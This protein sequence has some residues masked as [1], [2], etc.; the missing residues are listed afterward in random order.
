[1]IEFISRIP[2]A[3]AETIPLSAE[4]GKHIAIAKR[5]GD[6]WFVGV[7]TNNEARQVEIDFSFLPP[8]DY[9]AEV[10]R[11]DETTGA[12]AKAITREIISVN[13]QSKIS[14][15]LAAGG[16]AAIYISNNITGTAEES[17]RQFSIFL[18]AEG[19]MMTIQSD[20]IIDMLYIVDL[21]G[22]LLFS[23]RP[24]FEGSWSQLDISALDA[25]KIY[26]VYGVF[27]EQKKVFSRK[28]VKP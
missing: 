16:G 15:A 19:T 12:N 17:S 28:F 22:K 3:W 10:I 26:I 21:S 5:K 14:Y 11:D 4:V 25:E 24:Q 8:G 18:N 7:M 1:V 13:D 27:K 2:T 9:L 23:G 6:E 20:G